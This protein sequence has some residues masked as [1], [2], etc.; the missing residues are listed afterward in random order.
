MVRYIHVGMII[1]FHN[2]SSFTPITI[3]VSQSC[4][5][6]VETIVKYGYTLTYLATYIRTGTNN[7]K[8]HSTILMF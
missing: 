7:T 6:L 1:I 8:M 2:K 3:M 4:T 5:H